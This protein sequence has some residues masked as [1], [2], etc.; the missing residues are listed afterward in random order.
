[1]RKRKL[2]NDTIAVWES[3]G[4]CVAKNPKLEEEL[5]VSP[6]TDRE[7]LYAYVLTP[8]KPA[9]LVARLCIVGTYRE[10]VTTFYKACPVENWMAKWDITE[11]IEKRATREHIQWMEKIQR[12]IEEKL[13]G[14]KC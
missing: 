5:W 7:W 10:P 12:A 4:C 8:R 6:K 13:K 11:E 3:A 14:I 2:Q 9:R 1:M